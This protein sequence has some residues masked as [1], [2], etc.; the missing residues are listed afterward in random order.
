MDVKTA[1][2]NGPLKEEVYVAQPDGFV[3]PDHPDKVYR[4]RKA[5]YG[6]KQAP[7]AWYD[8]L[9]KF[10]ISKG[11][12]KDA[13]HAE[14]EYVALSASCAQVMWMRTQLQDY[15]FNYNK[16]PLYWRRPSAIVAI[17]CQK[18]RAA[19]PYQAYPYSGLKNK[20]KCM[21]KGSKEKKPSTQLRANRVNTYA[22]R[23]TMLITDI[24]DDIMDP[25]MQCTT[26]PSH[27]GFS[28]K[29]LVSFVMEIHTTSIDF[30]TP[31][32]INIEM[33]MPHSQL[34]VEFNYHMLIAQT[35]KIFYKHQDSRI[36]KLKKLKTKTSA[37]TLKYK[38]SL[39]DNHSLSREI[40]ST[41]IKKSKFEYRFKK[42]RHE[43]KVMRRIRN[44]KKAQDRRDKGHSSLSPE[45]ETVVETA[46][47]SRIIIK[48]HGNEGSSRSKGKNHTRKDTT[49]SLNIKLSRPNDKVLKKEEPR[50]ANNRDAHRQQP[51]SFNAND[52]PMPPS[53]VELCRKRIFKEK[54]KNKAKNNKTEHEMEKSERQSQIKAGKSQ[55]QQK[56]QPR[57]KSS[58][59]KRL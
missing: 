13:D 57:Q 55:S 44:R 28:Q 26:L 5:L 9:S 40:V 25:V 11:F 7:R 21:D 2:L 24:E 48:S 56:S 43:D 31:N 33:V 46:C 38:I 14:A 49:V 8:E 15:G 50:D 45:D 3:D 42:F 4:L 1:F 36:M 12:T 23:I 29:K 34:E 20:K 19:L 16:I 22:V 27:S 32:T 39:K 53:S 10:L 47:C 37:Q 51:L 54:D 17:S 58:Q 52:I 59:D 35:T 30:L 41:L 18:P 6:L